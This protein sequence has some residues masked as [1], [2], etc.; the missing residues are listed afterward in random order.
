MSDYDKAVKSITLA[1]GETW[2]PSEGIKYDTNKPDLAL[3]PPEFLNEVALALMH[4]EKKYGRYN[5][6]GGM[7]WCRIAAAALR[8][9]TA[10][11]WGE[12]VDS[13]SGLNHL[14]HAGACL[15]MLAVFR[16]RK[17]G[18]DNRYKP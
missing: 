17:L 9:I 18:Q 7:A 12:D 3:L 16:H 6:T 15:S 13:E 1:P 14:A 4:G 5:F 2:K 10:W 8:H 11:T